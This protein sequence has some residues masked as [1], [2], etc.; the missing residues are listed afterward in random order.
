M[1][2]NTNQAANTEPTIEAEAQAPAEKPKFV[3]LKYNHP[4][5]SQTTLYVTSD[6]IT[7]DPFGN[8]PNDFK[9][10]RSLLKATFS[11]SPLDELRHLHGQP[12]FTVI[13]EAGRKVDS[14]AFL[15]AHPDA[16]TAD[17]E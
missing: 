13:D 9:T 10:L 8:V 2:K 11:V 16:A 5:E 1:P 7:L 14:D 3:R 15:A 4:R 6:P 17:A 12:L